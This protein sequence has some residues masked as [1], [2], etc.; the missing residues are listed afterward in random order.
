MTATTN[1]HRT[2]APRA[3]GKPIAQLEEYNDSEGRVKFAEL[4]VVTEVRDGE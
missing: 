2:E 3:I 1:G 4:K